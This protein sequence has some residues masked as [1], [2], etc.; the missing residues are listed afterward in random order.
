MSVWEFEFILE[1]KIWKEKAGTKQLDLLHFVIWKY[2]NMPVRQKLN[3]I[4]A[5]ANETN[6]IISNKNC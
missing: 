4:Q 2:V 1:N 3:N 5:W 6:R